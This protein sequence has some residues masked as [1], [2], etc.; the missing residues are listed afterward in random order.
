MIIMTMFCDK[1]YI[2]TY[3]QSYLSLFYMTLQKYDY[4]RYWCDIGTR[5]L[6]LLNFLHK[7]LNANIYLYPANLCPIVLQ[8]SLLEKKAQ[9][10][11]I[12]ERVS[13]ISVVFFRKSLPRGF[14]GCPRD[15]SG[16]HISGSSRTDRLCGLPSWV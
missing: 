13:V 6:K 10:V 16:W 3:L 12:T 9:N 8:I 1:L 5:N 2:Y 11:I 14:I 4:L 15:L 7:I